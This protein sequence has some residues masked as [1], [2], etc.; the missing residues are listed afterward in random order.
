MV[1]VWIL[2]RHGKS[3][4]AMVYFPT[5]NVHAL[6]RNAFKY[7]STFSEI[8][9]VYRDRDGGTIAFYEDDN[10]MKYGVDDRKIGLVAR[11]VITK[12]KSFEITG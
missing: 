6:K 2:L 11:T 7:N 1:G 4:A 10:L 5:L 3:V 9:N 8:S 12:F